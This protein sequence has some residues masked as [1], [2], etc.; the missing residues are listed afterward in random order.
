MD[1]ERERKIVEQGRAQG[2][3][4]VSCH[5]LNQLRFKM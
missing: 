3:H 1:R 4:L 5:K 2:K